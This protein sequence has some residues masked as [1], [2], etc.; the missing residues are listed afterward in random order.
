M[1]DTVD[2]SFDEA[3]DDKKKKKNV[4]HPLAANSHRL[5]LNPNGVQY[6][7]PLVGYQQPETPSECPLLD[8]METR[9]RGVDLL[10][11]DIHQ[12]LLPVCGVHQLCYLCV[13]LIE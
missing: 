13:S 6:S 5:Q 2:N 11:G 7:S 10:S 4:M 8:A 3:D 9:C 12:E 1:H